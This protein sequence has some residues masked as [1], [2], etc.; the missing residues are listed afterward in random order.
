MHFHSAVHTFDCS[1]N[2]TSILPG[3]HVYHKICLGSP[4]PK[5]L[6]ST[7]LAFWEYWGGPGSFKSWREVLDLTGLERVDILK[8]DIEGF[9]YDGAFRQG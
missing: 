4:P 6:G 2:G 5:P 7:L 8:I 9:E 3:R 1:Y